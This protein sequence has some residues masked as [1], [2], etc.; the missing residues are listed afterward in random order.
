MSEHSFA[1]YIRTLGRGKTGSRSL[2]RQ[3]ARDAFAMVLCG[4]AKPVQIGAFLM[5]L[6]VKEESAE[7]LAGFV[8][9]SRD[10][11]SAPTGLQADLDW[12]SYAGKRKQYPWYLVAALALAHSG[13]RVFMHGAT[14]HTLGRVYTEQALADLGIQC[15]RDWDSVK[16]QLDTTCFSF[17]PLDALCPPLQAL[18][19]LRGDFGLRSPVHSLSRL[20]NPLAAQY[21]LQSIFHPSYADSHQQAAALLGQPHAAVFKGEAGEAESRPE[22][23]T[24]VFTV[25]NG[26]LGQEEWPA[27]QGERQSAEDSLNNHHLQDFLE[28]SIEDAYGEKAVIGTIAIALRLRTPEMETSAALEQGGKLLQALRKDWQTGSVAFR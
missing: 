2:S 9:A 15:A 6:R 3:E 7:E 12:S 10:W 13:I 17:M 11:I 20:L 4:E 23:R 21:S 8:E 26:K 16:R 24:R 5:L 14:G 22:A 25:H 28:G 19:D 27:L 1:P 18:M